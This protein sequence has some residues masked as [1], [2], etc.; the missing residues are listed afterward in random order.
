MTNELKQDFES[1]LIKHLLFKSKLRSFLYGSG[2][3]EGPIRDP[4]QCAF[5]HWIRDRALRDYQHLPESR[6]LDRVHVQIHEQANRLMDLHQKGD[7]ETAL[8]GLAAV[9]Q[10]ADHITSLLRTMEER[11]R[12]GK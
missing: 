2:T 7:R 4:Q 12:T 1:A 10:L 9:E 8:A 11:L 5:G 6:E 3:S